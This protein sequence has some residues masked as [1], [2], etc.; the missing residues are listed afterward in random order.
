MTE[1]TTTASTTEPALDL[2]NRLA[3]RIPEA[4]EA[5]GISKR[6]VEQLIKSGDIPHLRV[7]TAVLL[8]VQ[9]LKRWLIDQAECQTGPTTA[10][11]T[12]QTDSP[13]EEPTSAAS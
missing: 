13:A 10:E 3:L 8:P 4:A 12:V 9:S 11:D 7:N 1:P 5:L 6:L 2:T